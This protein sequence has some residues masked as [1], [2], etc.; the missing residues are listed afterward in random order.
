MLLIKT[1]TGQV[2]NAD[3]VQIFAIER[4]CVSVWSNFI[5]AVTFTK[6]QIKAL[7]ELRAAGVLNLDIKEDFPCC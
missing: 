7:N 5:R 6:A 1:I 3:S 4:G 2:V